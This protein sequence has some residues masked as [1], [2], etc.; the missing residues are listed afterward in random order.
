MKCIS[1]KI[2]PKGRIPAKRDRIPG[3]KYQGLNGMGL[4]MVDTRQGKSPDK[5]R[6]RPSSVPARVRGP[7]RNA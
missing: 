7:D 6:L 5:V 2:D 1:M 3:F 4:L